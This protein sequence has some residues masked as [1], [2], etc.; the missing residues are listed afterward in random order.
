MT[1]DPAS[2]ENLHDIVTPEAA[3][4]WPLAPGWYGVALLV[5]ILSAWYVVRRLRRWRRNAYRRE[6]LAALA[7]LNARSDRADGRASVLAEAA[8]LLRRVALSAYPRTQ[9]ATL[10]GDR[11]LAFLDE[12]GG[13]G[14]FAGG[15]GRVLLAAAYRPFEV[16]APDAVEAALLL[17]ERWIRR[18]RAG[19]A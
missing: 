15:A 11:W 18:H 13:R 10:G 16:P 2:L 19:P 6:A 3:G 1:T 4:W 5:L 17:C 12:T 14:E 8:T 9:V 7:L